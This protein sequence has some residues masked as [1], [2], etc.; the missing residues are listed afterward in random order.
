M[1]EGSRGRDTFLTGA[2]LL[3]A[4]SAFSRVLG[5]T[6]RIPL[7]RVMGDE[8]I[9]LYQMAYPIYSVMLALSTTGINIAVSKLVAEKVAQGRW[10]TA[11]AV[12]RQAVRLLL[13][14]GLA[15]SL[16]LAVGAK[17]IAQYVAR[18]PR[19]YLALLAV[20]PA[21][22]LVAIMAA[23]R[24][25]FQG[26]QDMRPTAWS[27]VV[28]QIIRV[29]TMFGLGLTLLP[30][31]ID[32]AAAGAVFGAVTGAIAGLIYLL[33]RY[34]AA[35][36]AFRRNVRAAKDDP[37]EPGRDI[38]RQILTV[39]VPIS[40]A[41][42]IMPL[43][44]FIDMAIVP[45]RLQGLGYTIQEATGLYGQLSG[46][47]Y[48]LIY[49]PTIFTAALSVSLVPAVSE[50]QVKHPNWVRSR[51][52]LA[53]RLNLLVSIPSFV[54]L[55]V[56]A[57]EISTLLYREPAAGLALL[58]LTPGGVFLTVQMTSGAVL[59]GLGRSD[60]PVKHLMVGAAVKVVLTW[61]LSGTGLGI[62]G[63]ALATDVGFAVNAFLNTRAA[64]RLTGR[65]LETIRHSFIPAIGGI[66]MGIA[67]YVAKAGL[68]GR[69]GNTKVT[70]LAIGLGIFVYALLILLMGGVTASELEMVPL[71]GPFAAR[72]LRRLHLTRR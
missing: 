6:A 55:A 8:G 54:G 63:A 10:R 53:T 38:M 62:A 3:A 16:G 57:T 7:A 71:A 17:P 24:G 15:G 30:R 33:R 47:A 5:A 11:S 1:S 4:S 43:M 51:T 72:V 48:P 69:L 27:Q 64:A 50:A 59:Q 32:K 21:L 65:S 13:V 23:M 14:L 41:S 20:S 36:S 31:G 29:I 22:L 66:A 56:L 12:F 49:V 19:A 42:I 18:D 67:V 60:L 9:G 44:Q 40:L 52:M 70:A 61:I 45:G 46:M 34:Y 28:E 39:A 26:L 37:G 2:I 35:Q 25:L 58:W 68:A